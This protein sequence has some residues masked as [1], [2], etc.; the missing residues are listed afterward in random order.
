[1]R[2]LCRGAAC[3]CVMLCKLYVHTLQY[4]GQNPSNSQ[5]SSDCHTYCKKPMF[6]FR[7]HFYGVLVLVQVLLCESPACYSPELAYTAYSRWVLHS[8]I[9]NRWHITALIEHIRYILLL[10]LYNTLFSGPALPES[11][12]LLTRAG[13]HWLSL[14]EFYTATYLIVSIL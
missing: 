2:L 10:C 1:M 5:H 14:S 11:C 4:I 6:V 13:L 12:L 7:Q 8:Y 9:F 3:F